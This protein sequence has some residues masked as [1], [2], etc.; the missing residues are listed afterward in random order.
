MP[1][2]ILDIN[3][4]PAKIYQEGEIEITIPKNY[5]ERHFDTSSKDT[6]PVYLRECDL[7]EMLALIETE[8]ASH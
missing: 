6:F 3:N 2:K 4:Y 7:R 1:Q 8:R 5:I